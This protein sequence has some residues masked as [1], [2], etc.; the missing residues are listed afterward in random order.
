VLQQDLAEVTTVHVRSV[1]FG[2]TEGQAELDSHSDPTVLGNGLL[3]HDLVA[4]SHDESVAQCE[5]CKTVTG[6]LANDHPINGETYF[7]IFHQAVLIP[8]LKVSLLSL[9]QMH[10]NDLLLM[11]IPNL[12]L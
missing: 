10:D 4:H 3:I 5:H 11:T 12:G 9:M 1:M 6:V 7:L 2:I 8:T